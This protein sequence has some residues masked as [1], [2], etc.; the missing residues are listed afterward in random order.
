MPVRWAHAA[1]VAASAAPD[2]DVDGQDNHA[3]TPCTVRV[4]GGGQASSA[5]RFG[6]SARPLCTCSAWVKRSQRPTLVCHTS[7]RLCALEQVG[8]IQEQM[9]FTGASTRSA[10]ALVPCRAAALLNGLSGRSRPV[11]PQH[12]NPHIMAHILS[13]GGDEGTHHASRHPGISVVFA[14][15]ACGFCPPTFTRI[16][17]HFCA[18]FPQNI[19]VHSQ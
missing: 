11:H 17:I 7:W 3:G 2:T 12:Q 4:Q 14:R 5:L 6:S 10:A 19:H 18:F 8:P 13:P 1:G 15:N 9:E 16:F